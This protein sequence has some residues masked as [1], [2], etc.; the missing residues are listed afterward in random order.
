MNKHI[1]QFILFT[2]FILLFINTGLKASYLIPQKENQLQNLYKMLFEENTNEAKADK[3]SKI[4]ELWREVLKYPES[5]WHGFD[6]LVYVGKVYSKDSLIRVYT[7][8]VPQIG[9]THR[10]F[11]F[12]QKKPIDN[13]EV[14]FYE[15]VQGNINLSGATNKVFSSGN[16][17][18][19]LYYSIIPVEIN[20]KTYYTLLALDLNNLITT[21]K[22]IDILYFDRNEVKFGAPVFQIGNQIQHRVIFEY[23]SRAVMSLRYDT[24]RKM[25]IHDHLSPSEP[26]Y[27]GQFQ[28]YGPDFSFD[29]MVFKGGLWKQTRDVNPR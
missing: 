18:G 26:R 2:I 1:R 28:F 27:R 3:I 29:G 5:F 13:E 9:G 19:A 16:W 25:I 12:V 14:I 8:N 15:L 11:G 6:S 22:L 24:N 7:W 21:R 10:Y 4:R 17:Y 23:S 20:Y